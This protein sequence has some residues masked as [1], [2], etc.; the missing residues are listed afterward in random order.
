MQK[1]TVTIGSVVILAIII[2]IGYLAYAQYDTYYEVWE[3]NW[4]ITIPKPAELKVVIESPPSFNGDGEGFFILEYR[5]KQINV[6]KNQ[7]FWQPIDENSISLVNGRVSRFKKMTLDIYSDEK[8]KYEKIY[9]NNSIE[10][11][12]GDLYFYKAKDDGSFCVAV[13]NVTKK[14]LHMMEWTQ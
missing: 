9:L 6:L 12:K 10:Y 8:E 5:D 11:G 13:L 3:K 4:G 7:N 1:R 14:R 2:G